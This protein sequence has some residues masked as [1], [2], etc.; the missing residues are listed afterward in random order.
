[1]RLGRSVAT[2]SSLCLIFGLSMC[3]SDDGKKR[4]VDA[5]GGEGGEPTGGGSPPHT[6]GSTTTAAEG[7]GAGVPSTAAAGEPGAP[8]GTSHGGVS[9][10]GASSEAGAAGTPGAVGAAGA[11]FCA[12]DET[13]CC[14]EGEPS[15]QDTWPAPCG[16]DMDSHSCC[17]A[18]VRQSCSVE[19]FD[20][21]YHVLFEKDECACAGG[22]CEC[23]C[24]KGDACPYQEAD[25]NRT[26]WHDNCTLGYSPT[27]CDSANGIRQ[28][29][30]YDGGKTFTSSPVIDACTGEGFGGG[31]CAQCLNDQD[32]LCDTDFFDGCNG[33]PTTCSDPELGYRMDCLDGQRN[34]LCTCDPH[35]IGV[36][37]AR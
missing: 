22:A 13:S 35:F 37:E 6:G 24:V 26:S 12:V 16:Q 21:N 27:C 1:M 20:G 33:E 29:C 10:G 9:S 23:A 8:G 31:D 17:D 25:C 36:P 2:V 7:G 34:V 3:G 28:R 19:Y 18:G 4:E 32:P 30:V 11:A 15:C 14:G 5:G